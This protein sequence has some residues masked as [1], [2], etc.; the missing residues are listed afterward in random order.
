MRTGEL[1]ELTVPSSIGIRVPSF[2]IRVHNRQITIASKA[3]IAPVR[4]EV[5]TTFTS[6]GFFSATRV[7]FT[8]RKAGANVKVDVS[9]Q[10]HMDLVSGD[11]VVVELK[12]FT[13]GSLPKCFSVWSSDGHAISTA[14]FSSDSSSS[15]LR[16]KI[17]GKIHEIHNVSIT[18]PLSAGLQLPLDAMP[19]NNPDFYISA[20]AQ[21]GNVIPT[22][23]ETSPS[24][25]Y[26]P[27]NVVYVNAYDDASHFFSTQ[28][29][30][31]LAFPVP[32][33]SLENH[34]SWNN[35]NISLANDTSALNQGPSLVVPNLVF[36]V[37]APRNL[38]Q[39]HWVVS[40][41][42]GIIGEDSTY[43]N[44]TSEPAGKYVMGMLK[45]NGTALWL[46][47]GAFVRGNESVAV[48]MQYTQGTT[49][50]SIMSGCTNSTKVERVMMGL[51]SSDPIVTYGAPCN[52]S[53]PN[54][55]IQFLTSGVK[56]ERL[57]RVFVAMQTLQNQHAISMQKLKNAPP[58]DLKLQLTFQKLI[59]E[60]EW[61]M[62]LLQKG[63]VDHFAPVSDKEANETYV[64]FYILK[65]SKR[66]QVNDTIM[67]PLPPFVHIGSGKLKRLLGV[68]TIESLGAGD[69]KHET[70]SQ[71]ASRC[72]PNAASMVEDGTKRLIVRKDIEAGDAMMIKI[73]Y[74]FE[75]RQPAILPRDPDQ[76]LTQC[77]LFL[78]EHAACLERNWNFVSTLRNNG[79]NSTRRTNG[80]NTSTNGTNRENC[81]CIPSDCYVALCN[82]TNY[83]A[84]VTTRTII[85]NC[86]TRIVGTNI[87]RLPCNLSFSCG[88][89]TFCP[90]LAYNISLPPIPVARNASI[91]S[92]QL[93]DSNL[94]QIVRRPMGI[95]MQ[96][97]VRPMMNVTA[98]ETIRVKLPGFTGPDSE[99]IQTIS[100]GA[101]YLSKASWSSF[102]QELVLTST[103]LMS[104]GTAAIA[105]IPWTHGIRT[106]DSG[107]AENQEDLTVATN[108][109]AGNVMPT[110][111]TS[112]NRRARS[113]YVAP[114]VN[115]TSN[116]TNATFNYATIAFMPPI[117]DQATNLSFTFSLNRALEE[118]ESIMVHLPKFSGGDVVG[119]GTVFGNS[120]KK[121]NAAWTI[122]CPTRSLN[123][124][125]EKGERITPGEH[126]DL[127]ISSNAGIRLP[128]SGIRANSTDFTVS[129]DASAGLARW[130]ERSR[131]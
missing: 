81:M 19:L 30:M 109:V 34:T 14:T 50:V 104:R 43:F 63:E 35:A 13:S 62:T 54:I 82:T 122:R 68:G 123:L 108:A 49:N 84:L 85:Q 31:S 37:V 74:L 101:N 98:G 125:V 2:G 110:S 130:Q 76:N 126:V 24:V 118:Y 129:T 46:Q 39:G 114:I 131:A 41:I 16:F 61:T 124:I 77:Q 53:S 70:A 121:F 55:S 72:N 90:V 66:I 106:P 87:T 48:S 79:T 51:Y 22:L 120:G 29:D 26:V 65:T 15:F 45:D 112:P 94:F 97:T 21:A 88:N 60:L 7:D 56:Q 17:V 116:Q 20:T 73:S 27:T 92:I 36:T 103:S 100:P 6:V 59:N 10:N 117:A 127:V 57:E 3:D 1:V 28:L 32:N 67:L 18:V 47:A 38:S 128:L 4:G 11:E 23:L 80:T 102:N 5:F 86:S 111:I 71:F 105:I 9:F 119:V 8:P 91:A 58:R 115:M 78:S 99:C 113:H 25:G 95:E 89:V 83:S 44:V 96:F 33:T 69:L 93:L 107:L 12:G 42:V 64:L 75:T 52:G 40:D